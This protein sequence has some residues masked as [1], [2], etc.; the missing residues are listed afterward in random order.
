MHLQRGLKR[1]GSRSTCSLV[2]MVSESRG[3]DKH[4]QE[5][6]VS[7]LP[8]VDG[9]H[10][11]SAHRALIYL[12][13]HGAHSESFLLG[14]LSFYLERYQDHQGCS[15]SVCTG[16]L[17]RHPLCSWNSHSTMCYMS[18]ITKTVYVF[19]YYYSCLPGME[20]ELLE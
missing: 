17:P 4:P 10:L 13:L 1:F 3:S 15:R 7:S 11:M 20:S 14:R 16:P 6:T 5:S 9:G 8:R 19:C 2:L 18:F 12:G